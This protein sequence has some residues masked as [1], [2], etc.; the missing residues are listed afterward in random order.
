M[1]KQKTQISF[2][3]CGFVRVWEENEQYVLRRSATWII[4]NLRE[5]R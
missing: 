3:K 2:E 5:E 1:L 4:R